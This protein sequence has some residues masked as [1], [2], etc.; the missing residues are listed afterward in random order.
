[1][2]IASEQGSLEIQQS[3]RLSFGRFAHIFILEKDEFAPLLEVPGPAT[4]HGSKFGHVRSGGAN[5]DQL[6]DSLLLHLAEDIIDRGLQMEAS[7][8]Q[9]EQG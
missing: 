4:A 8:G 5:Q 9:Q 7:P 3:E 1:M 2:W 6:L